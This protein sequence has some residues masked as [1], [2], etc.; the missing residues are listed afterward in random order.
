MPYQ[1]T[2]FAQLL[3]AFPRSRFEALNKLHHQGRKK[4]SLS[5]W[6]HLVAMLF[7]QGSG[8]RSLRDLEAVVAR[9]PG[10]LQHLGIEGLKRS[11]LSDANRNRPSPLF[12]AVAGELALDLA[13]TSETREIVRLI[14][15][16]HMFAG[17]KSDCWTLTG[18]I[19]LH[20]MYG[21]DGARPVCLAVAPEKVNDIVM[22]RQM[23][24][25]EDVTYVFDKAY[26]HFAFWA[27][28]DA[29]GSRFVT[30][31]KCRSFYS[32]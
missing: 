23:P 24:I 2:I 11:T 7:A 10:L 16:T 4:R 12:E 14:D 27:M 22:A 18:G 31:L 6:G 15:A 25:E 20:M 5:A 3:K 28:I 32:T 19:K 21:L 13:K 30:R 9:Q 1:S 8:A 26:Y 17:H 29:K